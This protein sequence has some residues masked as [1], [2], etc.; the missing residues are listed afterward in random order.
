MS[1]F[2]LQNQNPEAVTKKCSF[3]VGVPEK[4]AKF[5]KKW[6][7]KPECLWVY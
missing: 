2:V 1:F 5:L 3:K 4:K 6:R 7:L